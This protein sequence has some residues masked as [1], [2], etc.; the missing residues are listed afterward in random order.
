MPIL[1]NYQKI[2]GNQGLLVCQN[3]LHVQMGQQG[4]QF[5]DL[6]A[7]AINWGDRAWVY[8]RSNLGVGSVQCVLIGLL[9][10]LRPYMSPTGKIGIDGL[11]PDAGAIEFVRS[12][13]IPM[14]ML[15]SLNGGTGGV[16]GMSSGGDKTGSGRS[17]LAAPG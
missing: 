12:A 4:I 6:Q 5:G 11:N 3:N 16:A 8:G 2:D 7:V 1:K 17:H 13:G 10:Q 14:S 9:K 15:T